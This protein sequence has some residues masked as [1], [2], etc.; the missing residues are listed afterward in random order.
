MNHWL[1]NDQFPI[2]RRMLNDYLPSPHP[3]NGVDWKEVERIKIYVQ[4]KLHRSLNQQVNNQ[5]LSENHQTENFKN[6][7]LSEENYAALDNDRTKETI[8]AYPKMEAVG[9]LHRPQDD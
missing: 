5:P 3:R 2:I 6:E 7:L 8:T 4:L 9:A 1:I